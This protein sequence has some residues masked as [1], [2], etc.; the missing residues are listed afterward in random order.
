MV[1]EPQQV[2]IGYD[3]LYELFG[4]RGQVRMSQQSGPTIVVEVRHTAR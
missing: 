2:L 1:S 4:Q 3:G